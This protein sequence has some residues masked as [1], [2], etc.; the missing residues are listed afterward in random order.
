MCGR[1][2]VTSV[3]GRRSRTCELGSSIVG[4]RAILLNSQGRIVDAR[5]M[6]KYDLAANRRFERA[7]EFVH[8]TGSK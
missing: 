5:G 4:A 6:H 1:L 7:T 2:I 3:L 8:P